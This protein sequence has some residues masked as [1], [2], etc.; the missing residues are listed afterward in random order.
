MSWVIWLGMYEGKEAPKKKKKKAKDSGAPSPE[1]LVRVLFGWF[2]SHGD[3]PPWLDRALS[4]HTAG[5]LTH[6]LVWFTG[7]L[8]IER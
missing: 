5:L 8:S 3:G 2:S 6:E 1:F 4:S 7:V